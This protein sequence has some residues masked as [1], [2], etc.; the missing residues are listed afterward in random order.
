MVEPTPQEM[1]LFANLETDMG[2]TDVAKSRKRAEEL[3][4]HALEDA[5]LKV[6]TLMQNPKPEIQLRAALAIID[7]GLG[8]MGAGEGRKLHSD[9]E[10]FNFVND[11]SIDR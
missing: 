9:Q 7:R 10:I 6:L 1:A 3:F 2:M 8:R 11:V 4:V 5:V